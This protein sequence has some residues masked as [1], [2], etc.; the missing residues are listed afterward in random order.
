MRK[1]TV[2]HG[3][4]VS[5]VSEQPGDIISLTAE[6]TVMAIDWVV[7][8]ERGS[9]KGHEVARKVRHATVVR[10]DF[11]RRRALLTYPPLPPGAAETL[12]VVIS[13]VLKLLD[14]F[15]IGLDP[16]PVRACLSSLL[17]AGA[18]R[19]ALSRGKFDTIDGKFHV[20]SKA[21]TRSLDKVIAGLLSAGSNESE[22]EEIERQISESLQKQSFQAV[23][24]T[25]VDEKV[26]TR[27]EF[28]PVGAEFLFFWGRTD[29]TFANVDRMVGLLYDLSSNMQSADFRMI[30][31]ALA[32]VPDGEIV[33]P[34]EF[35][36]R[37][38]APP[39]ETRRA[40]VEAVNAGLVVPVYR[41]NADAELLDEFDLHDWTSDLPSLRREFTSSAGIV[42]D[43][44]DARNIRVGF[45]RTH[46]ATQLDDR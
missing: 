3:L 32:D 22:R 8:G 13:S 7:S 15:G 1:G 26:S 23:T 14:S 4:R 10:I 45:R 30:W 37:F 39:D 19:V 5:F 31:N 11:A 24:L 33:N 46:Y 35:A 41:L 38:R 25:W 6:R 16:L 20:T 9:R 29:R 18:R 34:G 44:S 42:V 2:A 17:A 36:S 21:R 40:L 28:I 27:V 12:E 43:G